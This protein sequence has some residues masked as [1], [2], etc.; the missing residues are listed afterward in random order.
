[1]NRG[2]ENVQARVAIIRGVAAAVAAAVISCGPAGAQEPFVYPTKG[3]TKDQ[4]EKD[5]YSCMQWA[6]Q[7]T[8]FDPTQ[9]AQASAPPPEQ[10]GGVLRGGAGGAALGAV[11]GAIAGSAGTGAAI[12]AATGGLIG[13]MRKRQSQKAEEQYAQQQTADYNKRR[14]DYE[15]ARGACL[16]GKGYTVK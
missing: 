11:G 15:R 7:Q 1:M 2:K 3:Q 8:G 13:G 16:E 14:N 6:K 10:K 4:M 12:G 9:R 5:K